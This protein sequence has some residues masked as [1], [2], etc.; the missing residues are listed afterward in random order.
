MD[1]WTM[2]DY[3]C[4]ALAKHIHNRSLALV[5]QSFG[6]LLQRLAHNG[7]HPLNARDNGDCG[8]VA[9]LSTLYSFI[10]SLSPFT[11]HLSPFHFTL[12]SVLFLA[13]PSTEKF[14]ALKT[15]KN[16]HYEDDFKKA[17]SMLVFFMRKSCS[18]RKYDV[19]LRTYIFIYRHNKDN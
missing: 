9:S 18:N 12:F 19:N 15:A 6:N 1:D 16:G 17:H 5:A 3:L 13:P 7:Q 10:C 8:E 14:D 11:F 4:L 2:D